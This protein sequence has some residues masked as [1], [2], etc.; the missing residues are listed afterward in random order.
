MLPGLLDWVAKSAIALGAGLNESANAYRE[1]QTTD[2]ARA[3]PGDGG[4][5]AHAPHPN[6]RITRAKFFVRCSCGKRVESVKYVIWR[7]DG[8]ALRDTLE[9]ANAARHNVPEV[10]A[11]GDLDTGDVPGGDDDE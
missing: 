3:E 8:T 5:D 9:E 11:T 4:Q 10:V 6:S 1:M 7:P 2:A